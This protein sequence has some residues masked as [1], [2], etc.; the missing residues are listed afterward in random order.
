M[1]GKPQYDEVAVIEAAAQAFRRHGYAATSLHELTAATGLSRSSLYQRFRDKEGLFQ[2]A[3]AAYTTRLLRRMNAARDGSP[4]E[5]L[6]AMLHD[7]APRPHAA[8]PPGCLLARSCAELAD[9]PAA[10]KV[11][12]LAGVAGQRQMFVALLREGRAAGELAA[13]ADLDALAWHFLGVAQ[14]LANLPNAGATPAML[15]RMVELGM[16]AW[17]AAAP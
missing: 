2:H 12:A 9:L 16:A 17:P 14:A 6:Q 4:R 1:S 3:L 11:E 10:G 8:D 13:D 7:L 15:G 5:R